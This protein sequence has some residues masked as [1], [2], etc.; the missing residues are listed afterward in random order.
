MNIANWCIKISCLH[1]ASS[2][3]V[4]RHISEHSTMSLEVLGEGWLDM[5]VRVAIG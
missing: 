3:I 2:P 1:I 5:R 4:L